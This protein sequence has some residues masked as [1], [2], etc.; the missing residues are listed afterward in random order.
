MRGAEWRGR[1]R[2][3]PAFSSVLAPRLLSW[4]CQ[5]PS[6]HVRSNWLQAP[7]SMGFLAA[8]P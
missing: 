3:A 7:G 4:G 8:D 5:Y 6:S 2:C 1:G